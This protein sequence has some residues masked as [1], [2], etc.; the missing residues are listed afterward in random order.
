MGVV[1]M[2][3]S[4]TGDGEKGIAPKDLPKDDVIAATHIPLTPRDSVPLVNPSE[5]GRTSTAPG[6]VAVAGIGDSSA[7]FDFYT[8]AAMEQ[9]LPATSPAV[10]ARVETVTAM[11]ISSEDLK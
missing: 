7:N 6:A 8:D 11:A 3:G 9:S 2:S 10:H 1:S 5:D 4:E